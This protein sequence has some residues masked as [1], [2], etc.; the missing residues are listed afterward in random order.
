M[1]YQS[2]MMEK[3]AVLTVAELMCAAART[4][5]KTRGMG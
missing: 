4:A 2:E 3:N 5:P 1:M